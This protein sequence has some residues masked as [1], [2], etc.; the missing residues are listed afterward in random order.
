MLLLSILLLDRRRSWAAYAK[1]AACASADIALK[2][3]PSRLNRRGYSRVSE[4]S[5]SAPVALMAAQVYIS[6]CSRQFTGAYSRSLCPKGYVF[7]SPMK[8]NFQKRR[9]PLVTR[10]ITLA[11]LFTRPMILGVRGLVL[12]S[13]NRVLLVRHTYVEGYWLPGGGVEHSETLVNSLARELMEEGNILFDERD[14]ILSG[15][16]LN[17]NTCRY[18]HEVLFVLRRFQQKAEFVPNYE[19]AES[20]FFPVDDL[21][22][23]TLPSVQ[24]RLAEVLEGAPICP[25]W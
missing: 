12:D 14:A 21:P 20:R 5:R 22:S 2:R 25:Y 18:N 9:P 7:V 19:I 24:S 15:I 13:E 8:E 4:I 3:Y 6:R 17:V 10:F 23:D 1:T 11:A 16:Y